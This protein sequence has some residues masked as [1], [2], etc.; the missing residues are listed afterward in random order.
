MNSLSSFLTLLLMLISLLALIID[1]A[2]N[3]HGNSDAPEAGKPPR[4]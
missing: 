2:L 3:D 4:L 1:P